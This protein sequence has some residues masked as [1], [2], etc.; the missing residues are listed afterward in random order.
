MKS[1]ITV[2]IKETDILAT[3]RNSSPKTAETHDKHTDTTKPT[4]SPKKKSDKKSS[5]P[6]KKTV[7]VAPVEE[8]A[9]LATEIS[10]PTT[11]K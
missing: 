2:D 4:P 5:K 1:I 8:V 10:T 3:M 7:I 9:P 11:T 6:T